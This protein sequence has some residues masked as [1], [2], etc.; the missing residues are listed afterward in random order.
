MI[1]F[2]EYLVERCIN[3]NFVHNQ[4]PMYFYL[5]VLTHG[6]PKIN[7]TM[8][9]IFLLLNHGKSFD[10]QYLAKMYN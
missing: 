5:S 3:H 9:M 1:N 4:H 10:I 2:H 6:K 7:Q 8:L